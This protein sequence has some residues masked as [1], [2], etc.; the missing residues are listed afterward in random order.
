MIQNILCWFEKILKIFGDCKEKLSNEECHHTVE[1]QSKLDITHSITMGQIWFQSLNYILSSMVLISNYTWCRQLWWLWRLWWLWLLWRL[2]KILCSWILSYWKIGSWKIIL[3]N[4]L[5]PM[6]C[7][8]LYKKLVSPWISD[9]RKKWV[10]GTNLGKV[11]P[12][13]ILSFLPRDPLH[14]WIP[15]L[16]KFSR[17]SRRALAIA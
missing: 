4:H 11:P 2:W 5:V 16:E 10:R 6:V 7:V 17:S 13:H 14:N 1:D 15:S 3:K 8:A 12:G 9:Q